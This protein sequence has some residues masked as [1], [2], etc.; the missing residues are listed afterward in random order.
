LRGDYA[1]EAVVQA[2]QLGELGQQIVVKGELAYNNL[3]QVEQ[4][5]ITEADYP[6]YFTQYTEKD[7][8]ARD[9]LKAVEDIRGSYIEDIIREGE[10]GKWK[11]SI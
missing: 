6:K 8:K 5:T 10:L 4:I 2:L 9:G 11:M 1:Y 7:N 3:R